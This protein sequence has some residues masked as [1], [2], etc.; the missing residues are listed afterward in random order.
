MKILLKK[1]GKNVWV[2][3]FVKG[4]GEDFVKEMG[5]N[6]WVK[7]FVK[8]MGENVVKRTGGKRWMRKVWV[9]KDGSKKH[10]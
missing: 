6:V 4:M 10:G 3:T 9:Q 7:T 8:G 2:K 5:K 1:W